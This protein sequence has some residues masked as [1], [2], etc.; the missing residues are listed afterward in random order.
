MELG[1]FLF[2]FGCSLIA[3]LIPAAHYLIKIMLKRLILFFTC[4]SPI[5]AWS[6]ADL[7][8]RIY[9]SQNKKE[10]TIDNIVEAFSGADVLFYGEEHNDS[11][12]HTLELALLEACYKAYGSSLVLSL[13]M[14][15][16]DVQLI[17]DEY[18]TG[19]IKEKNLLK[20]ARPWKNYQDYRPLVEFAK[21]N[22]IP[23]VAAN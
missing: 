1:G 17:L 12:S 22:G 16:T 2:T 20:E 10:T 19:V 7:S 13:E 14:F 15:E 21:Q 5:S 3:V 9:D 4:L 6:Q 8:Y 23:V 18:T 11:I